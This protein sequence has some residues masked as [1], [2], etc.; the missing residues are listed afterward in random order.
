MK[1][2]IVGLGKVGQK[3]AVEL[4]REDND[5]TV[6]DKN[7]E[8]L[9][10]IS[11]M[12]D[13][14]GIVGNGSSYT[15]Q[16]EA[17]IETADLLIAVTGSDELNLL[18]CLIAKK[19]GNC[20]TIARVRDPEYN[21]ELGF[22]KEELGLAMVINPELAAASEIARVLKFPS[23][24]DVCS[25]PRSKADL[26]TFRVPKGS[27]LDGIRVSDISQKIRGNILICGVERGE[28]LI[29]PNGDTELRE[30]DKIS[31]VAP[32][33]E[34][35]T[36]FKQVGIES[37]QATSIM[38]VG[39]GTIA[40]YLA[41]MLSA[42]GIRVKIVEKN[43]K[44]CD[45]LSEALPRATVVYGDG[46]DRE[47]LLEE[48][49]GRYE[50]FAAL[51]N[52][53]EENIMLSL[54]AKKIGVRKLVTKVN[55]IA[56]DEVIEELD[57]DTVIH[58][59]DITY[60][61]ILRYVRSKQNSVGSNV[62]TLH[63]IIDNKAEALEFVIRENSKVTDIPLQDLKIRSGILVATI[64][65]NRK[66]IIPRG[67]DKLMKGDTVIIITEHTCINNIEDILVK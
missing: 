48:G 52:I 54:F 11:N 53:D 46:A 16:M 6:I 61:A 12:C 67:T 9:E 33:F 35:N 49:I 26:L 17:G 3:L 38:I 1:I 47:L 44:R 8:A 2:I 28:Q 34:T 42:S 36:F 14:M 55:R 24:T 31:I 21:A 19:A 13:I 20:Q 40:F 30:K 32:A 58:P 60:E 57:L 5:I 45:I 27:V 50:S 66:I 43:L 7:E 4:S 18:C 51:T 59:K 10:D 22:I 39:G 23:A 62:E 56:F 15:T 65:R 63:K 64:N 37:N 41:K 25:F 29:I